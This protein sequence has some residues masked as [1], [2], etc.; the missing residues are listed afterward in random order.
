[1]DLSLMVGGRGGF[2]N[3]FPYNILKVSSHNQVHVIIFF[4]F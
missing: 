2:A 3:S 1:M 4:Y